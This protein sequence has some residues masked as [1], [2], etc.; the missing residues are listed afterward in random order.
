MLDTTC[1][2]LYVIIIVV[3]DTA[4]NGHDYQN[5]FQFDPHGGSESCYE[6]LVDLITR[7]RMIRKNSTNFLQ[8]LE[9]A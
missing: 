2:T 3:P 6:T 9:T 5:A 1:G 7:N 4:H 8:I